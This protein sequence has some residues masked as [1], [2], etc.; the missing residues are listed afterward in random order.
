MTS[1]LKFGLLFL[2]RAAVASSVVLAAS[3]RQLI[4]HD[5]RLVAQRD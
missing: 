1:P 5:F 3:D 4:R 2:F